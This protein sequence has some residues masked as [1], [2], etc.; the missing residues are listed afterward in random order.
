MIELIFFIIVAALC[1]CFA[2]S[3]T[4]RAKMPNPWWIKSVANT[5]EDQKLMTVIL[6]RVIGIV[7]GLIFSLLAI[8]ALVRKL[9]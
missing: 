8:S 9:P 6:F 4:V 7:G 5:A 2:L 3:K 1:W